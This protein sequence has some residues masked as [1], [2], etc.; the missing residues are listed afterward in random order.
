MR[1]GVKLIDAL[2]N[3]HATTAAGKLTV[4][5]NPLK[6]AIFIMFPSRDIAGLNPSTGLTAVAHNGVTSTVSLSWTGNSDSASYNV[7]RSP[8]QGGGYIKIGT[9]TGKSF[10]DANVNNGTTYY[11]VVRGVDTLGNE[12][13]NSN[14]ANATPAFRSA[15]LFSSGPR[16]LIRQSPQT[17]PPST[18]RSMCRV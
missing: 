16:R 7:Y 8:V 18:A 17:T 3:G 11:Y 14:E 4:T 9:P 6:A 10:T 2:G 5:L 12:G 1:D 13:A 15:M